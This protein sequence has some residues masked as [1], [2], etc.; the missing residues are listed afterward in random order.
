MPDD[1]SPQKPNG[2][3]VF[4]QFVRLKPMAYHLTNYNQY[5]VKIL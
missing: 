4:R 5:R 1:F 2:S 3:L